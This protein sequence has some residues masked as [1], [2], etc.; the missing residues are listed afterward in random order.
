M[1]PPQH[2]SITPSPH[3]FLSSSP[4]PKPPQLRQHPKQTSTLRSRPNLQ[5]PHQPQ[6][7]A[8]TPRFSFASRSLK[9][10]LNHDEDHCHSSAAQPSPSLTGIPRP[11]LRLPVPARD[12]VEE[13]N[14][15][16]WEDGVQEATDDD[17]FRVTDADQKPPTSIAPSSSPSPARKRRRRFKPAERMD[18]DTVILSS[19][20]TPSPPSHEC[21]ANL[22]TEDQEDHENPSSPLSFIAPSAATVA[23]TTHPRFRPIPSSPPPSHSLPKFLLPTTP[24]PPPAALPNALSSPQRRISKFVPGGLAATMRDLVVETAVQ[25]QQVRGS[26]NPSGTGMVAGLEF[27]VRVREVRP[28]RGVGTGMV[29]VRE[30][31]DV[32]GE[33]E[34]EGEGNG[35]VLIGPGTGAG[36]GVAVSG[37]NVK[38]GDVV[39]VKRPVW[40]M[41]IAGE[42]WS[43]G[44]DWAVLR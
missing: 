27:R 15:G 43:V 20:P 29:L 28:Q 34:E 10:D 5:T 32:D 39:G 17:G 7:F 11:K 37:G 26:R 44:V 23:T 30:Q 18:P 12:V 25:Q 33:E 8:L 19:S 41:K 22:H 1:P 42:L 4:G 35:W 38:N 40:E 36:G 14:S 31:V 6:Q 16:E 24:S 13:G 9:A 3:R 2:P 21:A